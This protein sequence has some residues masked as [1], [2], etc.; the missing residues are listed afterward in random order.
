MYYYF[1]VIL[2][3]L[4]R[5]IVHTYYSDFS[6]SLW[7]NGGLDLA[8]V[9]LF[10]YW[11]YKQ[12]QLS[13]K[14]LAVYLLPLFG[15][16]IWNYQAGYVALLIVLPF[17]ILVSRSS[18]D[19]SRGYIKEL[20]Q[21][22]ANFF[23][24]PILV[25]IQVLK[26]LKGLAGKASAIGQYLVF[27][28]V[29]IFVG[30]FMIV[31]LALLDKDFALWLL[32]IKQILIFVKNFI[33]S[34]I[35]YS[36]IFLWFFYGPIKTFVLSK[37]VNDETRFL[38]IL[39]IV[40]LIVTALLISYGFYDTYILLRLFN[41][42]SLVYENV[43]K[44]TQL[45]FVEMVAMGGMILFLASFLLE[46]LDILSS[47]KKGDREIKI[48]KPLLIFSTFLLLLPLYNLFRALFFVYIPDFGLTARRLFGLYSIFAFLISFTYLIVQTL[49]SKK[50]SLFSNVY[51]WFFASLSIF[52]FVIPNNIVIYKSQLSRY[53][54]N[55]D[56]GMEYM[57]KL[58]TGKWSGIL[59]SWKE[60]ESNA[61]DTLLKWS[62]AYNYRDYKAFDGYQS[63]TFKNL[64][65]E[66]TEL[67]NNLNSQN[68]LDIENN[69]TDGG[70]Y[71]NLTFIYDQEIPNVKLSSYAT[72]YA[73]SVEPV[74]TYSLD[75]ESKSSSNYNKFKPNDFYSWGFSAAQVDVGYTF[76][77]FSE[78]C[79]P[80]TGNRVL[81]LRAVPSSRNSAL[82]KI[83]YTP[84]PPI[85]VNAY[86][87]Q[88]YSDNIYALC[89]VSYESNYNINKN[90]SA[91]CERNV[92]SLIQKHK[93]QDQTIKDKV[94]KEFIIGLVEIIAQEYGQNDS[95]VLNL[96][97]GYTTGTVKVE[98]SDSFPSAEITIPERP[99]PEVRIK[100][101]N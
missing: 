67:K 57:M 97:P 77:C 69:N 18:Q 3:A 86:E 78:V 58:N 82:T 41:A 49:S 62:L 36:G 65:D 101:I 39:K 1:A 100:P 2:I 17:I 59:S 91:A 61:N 20:F 11:L 35:A 14:L 10:S 6:A 4:F 50:S 28:T 32:N 13:P 96:S 33:L 51:I 7:I 60:D 53:L 88:L 16:V 47:I 75:T 64:N 80:L 54:S 38:G 93:L 30:L 9:S 85:W 12:K 19:L 29:G 26:N 98:N 99:L 68:Y 66:V 87:G 56:G 48:L 55:N 71:G 40:A 79:K 5:S 84:F 73:N 24:Y 37:S 70:M 27:I 8:F 63:L 94:S 44:N 90:G 89:E 83:D 31:I 76:S 23:A 43:G 74:G 25:F 52:V 22:V 34:L 95:A 42:L 21:L 92:R 81:Y 15:S 46:K 45:Y 72:L